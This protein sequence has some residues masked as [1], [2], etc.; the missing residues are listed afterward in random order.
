MASFVDLYLSPR[1]WPPVADAGYVDLPA[2]RIAATQ[3]A[4]AGR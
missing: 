3:D 4:W 1:V 2:D